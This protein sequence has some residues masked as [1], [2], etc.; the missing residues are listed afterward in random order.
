VRSILDGIFTGLGFALALFILASVR[1]II[2]AGSFMGTQVFP[3]E[4][5]IRMIV[6][7]P[8]AFISLGIII[9]A[10]KTITAGK[11]GGKIKTEAAAVTEAATEITETAE[12]SEEAGN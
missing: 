9:A 11:D 2:G 6:S 7:P 3:E 12:T 4:Y 10:F 8:G 5:A 1:E